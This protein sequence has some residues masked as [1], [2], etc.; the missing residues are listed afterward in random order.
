MATDAAGVKTETATTADGEVTAKV[1][2]PKGNESAKVTVP[3]KELSPGTVAVIVKS[4]GTEEIIKTSV[5]TED[6]LSFKATGDVAVMLVDNSKSFADVGGNDWYSNTVQF[7]ASRELLT[8]TGKDGFSPTGDM[9]RG[10]LVTVLARL[11]GQDTTTGE[12]WDSV[13]TAWAKESGIS[14]GAGMSDSITREQLAVMLYRYAKVEKADGMAPEEFSDADQVS[15]WAVRFGIINGA[16][17]KLNPAATAT[18][19]EVAIMLQRLI[20]L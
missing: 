5:V 10:M 14:D 20:A 9:T 6:G 11:D 19:A 2:L 4:D 3:V 12:S 13:G 18:R 15:A 8:G 16:N 17:G 1:T 7:A